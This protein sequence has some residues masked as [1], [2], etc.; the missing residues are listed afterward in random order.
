MTCTLGINNEKE[1]FLLGKGWYFICILCTFI[2]LFFFYLVDSAVNYDFFVC[3]WLVFTYFMSRVTQ[4][5]KKH[6][7]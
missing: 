5:A 3:G 1:M 4:M 2:L 7:R 6:M